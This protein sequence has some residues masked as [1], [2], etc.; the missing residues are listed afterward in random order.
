MTS[1][2]M[3]EPQKL[4][5]IS[6]NQIEVDYKCPECGKFFREK[7]DVTLSDAKPLNAVKNQCPEFPKSFE[8]WA[9]THSEICKLATSDLLN[10]KEESTVYVTYREEGSESYWS[11][12]NQLTFQFE[13]LHKDSDWDYEDYLLYIDR[14]YNRETN[15]KYSD[16]DHEQLCKAY[17][18]KVNLPAI[19]SEFEDDCHLVIGNKTYHFAE[20]ENGADDP[21]HPFFKNHNDQWCVA[22]QNDVDLSWHSVRCEL[23]S[24]RWENPSALT[25]KDLVNELLDQDLING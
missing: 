23:V 2:T 20:P 3:E 6:D 8:S 4:A 18:L 24:G 14:F 25:S 11:I 5:A 17:D 9:Q 12:V 19:K 16:Y 15:L 7:F 22:L 13:E 10:Q 1:V 21:H